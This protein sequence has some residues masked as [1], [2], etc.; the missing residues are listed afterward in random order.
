MLTGDDLSRR[1]VSAKYAFYVLADAEDT[2]LQQY[3]AVHSLTERKND[4]AF[5]AQLRRGLLALLS[6]IRGRALAACHLKNLGITKIGL[7]IPVQWGLDFEKV[8]RELVTEVFHVDESTTPKI[9]FFTE[10]EA[11]SRYLFKHHEDLLD[12]AKEYNSIMFCD[13]GGHNMVWQ[14]ISLARMF[15]NLALCWHRTAVFS[16]LPEMRILRGTDFSA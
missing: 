5:R 11:L 2:L 10:T 14:P 15:S 7:T 8:Y 16:A 1:S 12:G 3:P 13:F 4:P 6:A 9:F